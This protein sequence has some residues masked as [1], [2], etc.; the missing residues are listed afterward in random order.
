MSLKSFKTEMSG[1]LKLSFKSQ[2]KP[3]LNKQVKSK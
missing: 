1:S 3:K 2:N